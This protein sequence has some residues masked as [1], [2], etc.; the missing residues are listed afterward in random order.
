MTSLWHYC[1]ILF[2][3]LLIPFRIKRTC[4]HVINKN[5]Y[6]GNRRWYPYFFL[7]NFVKWC[8]ILTIFGKADAYI[9]LQTKY[10]Q[11]CPP[12]LRDVRIHLIRHQVVVPRYNTSTFGRRAF[13]VAGPTVWNSLPDKLCDP[14]LSI[15][16]FRRQLSRVGVVYTAH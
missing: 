12:L 11:N 7:N 1:N 14:S 5:V 6:C 13:S 8:S 16:S 4:C 10:Q 3:A 9:N 15:D 2:V